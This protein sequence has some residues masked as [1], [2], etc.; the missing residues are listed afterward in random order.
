[1]TIHDR[2]D[3]SYKAYMLITHHYIDIKLPVSSYIANRRVIFLMISLSFTCISISQ[4]QTNLLQI[5]HTS[6]VTI[7]KPQVKKRN[8]ETS[9]FAC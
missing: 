7:I 5:L 8:E 2:H 3:R 1:M 9:L 4:I 6:R